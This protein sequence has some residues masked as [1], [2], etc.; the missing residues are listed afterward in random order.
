M[1]RHR[2]QRERRGHQHPA[3]PLDAWGHVDVP[4]QGMQQQQRDSA[5]R[6]RERLEQ[7][8][9]DNPD[10]EGEIHPSEPWDVGGQRAPGEFA[11]WV[12]VYDRDPEL[13]PA[14]A[15]AT[16]YVY[17]RNGEPVGLS[18]AT[19]VKGAAPNPY[20]WTH[21][22]SVHPA[23]DCDGH[24]WPTAVVQV[25]REGPGSR[26]QRTQSTDRRDGARGQLSVWAVP[27]LESGEDRV[28][29]PGFKVRASILMR[30]LIRFREAGVQRVSVDLLEKSIGRL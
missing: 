15:L 14:R 17:S 25:T 11:Q 2:Q 13:T 6:R 30:L 12:R 18:L 20:D 28:Q 9:G 23:D 4:R 8:A 24:G 10:G 7:W 29:F 3:T 1:T 5:E 22:F 26:E 16:F 21:V 27:D 19:S